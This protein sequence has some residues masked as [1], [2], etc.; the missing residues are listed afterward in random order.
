MRA[1]S[2]CLGSPQIVLSFDASALIKTD[3]CQFAVPDKQCEM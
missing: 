1:A 2:A 3:T